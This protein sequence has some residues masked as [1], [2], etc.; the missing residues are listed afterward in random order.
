VRFGENEVRLQDLHKP[1][2]RSS[3]NGGRIVIDVSGAEMEVS[4]ITM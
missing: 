2:K 3:E 4:V 1:L